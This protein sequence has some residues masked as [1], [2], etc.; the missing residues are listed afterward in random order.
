MGISVR[1]YNRNSKQ[2]AYATFYSK[3]IPAQLFIKQFARMCNAKKNQTNGY[4]GFAVA[5]CS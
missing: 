3:R 2:N 4:N 1:F 5:A